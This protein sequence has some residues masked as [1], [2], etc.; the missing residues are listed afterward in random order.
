MKHLIHLMKCCDINK[1][2]VNIV[3]G[4]YRSCSCDRSSQYTHSAKEKAYK[5]CMYC[6]VLD[7]ISMFPQLQSNINKEPCET[8]SRF[9]NSSFFTIEKYPQKDQGDMV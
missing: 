5:C 6:I 4:I 8:F 9:K 3:S 7:T 1:P 2:V